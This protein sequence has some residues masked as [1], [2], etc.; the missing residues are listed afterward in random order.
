MATIGVLSIFLGV[1]SILLYGT[2]G[3]ISFGVL[4][5]IFS[6]MGLL[7]KKSLK[8]KKFKRFAGKTMAGIGLS[9]SIFGVLLSLSFFMFPGTPISKFADIIGPYQQQ[10]VATVDSLLPERE[11][12][13]AAQINNS[14]KSIFNLTSNSSEKS[15]EQASTDNVRVVPGKESSDLK[16]HFLNVGQGLS[17][18]AECDGHFLLY[19]G[20]DRYTSSFVVAYLKEAGVEKLDYVIA[21]H[22]DADHLNGVVGALNVFSTDL[23]L[24]PDYIATSK[25]YQSFT[26]VI[27][28]KQILVI[29]PEVKDVYSL[30]SATF[31]ILGPIGSEYKDVNDYSIVIMLQNG[32]DKV[33]ITGDSEYVSEKELCDSRADLSCDIYVAGHHGSGSSSSWDLLQETTPEYCVVSCGSDNSYG[34]PHDS[35]MEKLEAMEIEVFRTDKQGTITCISNG[36]GFT[37]SQ[38]P[39]NDYTPGR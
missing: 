11:Q 8:R 10:V 9:S 29:H 38:E 36:N 14:I 12:E 18:L 28:E 26:S 34:H 21:S 23:V 16:I 5:L 1:V 37:W 33:L 17:I 13:I 3:G 27:T 2:T 22:F 7:K 20:G 4:G 35:T 31:T 24:A 25:I 30:G 15:I 32:S 19:D 39:C 6:V